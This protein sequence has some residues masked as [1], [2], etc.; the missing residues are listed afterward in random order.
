[1]LTKGGRL[2][3]GFLFD[4]SRDKLTF[5]F[6]RMH[7]GITLNVTLQALFWT[8]STLTCKVHHGEAVKIKTSP[9][10]VRT[11]SSSP[12]SG[13]LSLCLHRSCLSLWGVGFH[14]LA[15][16][17]SADNKKQDNYFSFNYFQ[18]KSLRLNRSQTHFPAE[19]LQEVLSS[20]GQ[21]VKEK[22]RKNKNMI[23]YAAASKNRELS[24]I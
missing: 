10:R 12:L 17:V 2:H 11:A 4:S 24:S 14:K 1:M 23:W 6:I 8:R 22:N 3:T 7:R 18:N 16:H 9:C 21:V 19:W 15:W 5:R 20:Y 13:T